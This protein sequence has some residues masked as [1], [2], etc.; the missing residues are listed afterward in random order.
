MLRGPGRP[1]P[2]KG[3]HTLFEKSKQSEPGPVCCVG[4]VLRGVAR[5]STLGSQQL[6]RE[7]DSLGLGPLGLAA[8]ACVQPSFK[9]LA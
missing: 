2:K 3:S 4:R 5:A 9:K 1:G 6:E 7:V 8:Y